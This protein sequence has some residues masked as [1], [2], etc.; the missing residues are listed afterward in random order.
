MSSRVQNLKSLEDWEIWKSKERGHKSSP[1]D[2]S[3]FP[4][5]RGA[6]RERE[7]RDIRSPKPW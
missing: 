5:T 1:L 2:D 4:P 7:K 6:E 3:V